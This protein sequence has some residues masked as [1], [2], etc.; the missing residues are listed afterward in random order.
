MKMA[1]DDMRM[2]SGSIAMLGSMYLF[3]TDLPTTYNDYRVFSSINFQIL[4]NI[5]LL[6]LGKASVEVFHNTCS[7]CIRKTKNGNAYCQ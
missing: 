3:F 2:A 1:D 6:M 5:V 7:K 4:G